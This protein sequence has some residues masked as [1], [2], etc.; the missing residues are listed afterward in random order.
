MHS[1]AELPYKQLAPITNTQTKIA[2]KSSATTLHPTLESHS[3]GLSVTKKWVK[4]KCDDVAGLLR[5][6]YVCTFGGYTG[7]TV[8]AAWPCLTLL[9]AWVK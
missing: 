9:S 5:A 6:L 7:S 3:G 1:A 8:Q 4:R 2:G